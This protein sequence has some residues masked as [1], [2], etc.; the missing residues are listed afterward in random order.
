MI[1]KISVNLYRIYVN[2]FAIKVSPS[3]RSFTETGEGDKLN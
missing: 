2:S 1:E 3:I